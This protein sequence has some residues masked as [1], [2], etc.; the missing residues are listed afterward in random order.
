MKIKSRDWNIEKSFRKE[1]DLRERTVK[2]KNKYNRKEKY[3][4]S[5]KD[6][7]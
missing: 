1:I 3:R 6:W 7:L 2:P 4:K 5:V